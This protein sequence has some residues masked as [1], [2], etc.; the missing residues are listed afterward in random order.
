MKQ[1]TVSPDQTDN[2]AADDTITFTTA[3][4]NEKTEP[5]N[6]LKMWEFNYRSQKECKVALID[7]CKEQA[8]SKLPDCLIHSQQRS[9]ASKSALKPRKIHQ[10]CPD[11]RRTFS[12]ADMHIIRHHANKRA[13]L[14]CFDCHREFT[15]LPDIKVHLQRH[16]STR[17]FVCQFCGRQYFNR[18][19]LGRH[20]NE[21]HSAKNR[22]G[23]NQC[24][25]TF[26][27]RDNLT[28]H[29]KTHSDRRPFPCRFC[30]LAFK[31]SSALRTHER[32]HA[33]VRLHECDLCGKKFRDRSALRL[34]IRSH[35]GERP[36]PCRICDKAF[37]DSST[38]THH[39]RAM[40]SDDKPYKCK[41]CSHQ[42]AISSNLKTHYRRIH[43][44]IVTKVC[45]HIA[46]P[47]EYEGTSLEEPVFR[48][49]I[50]FQ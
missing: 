1:M 27:A 28:K 31:T 49:N 35:T 7:I 37:A 21:N 15:R 46:R 11:C 9:T 34:H 19:T 14:E 32:S 44:V 36:F 4:T 16:S 39:E 10:R 3:S 25:K 47:A 13:P 50:V 5:S 22:F 29:L 48:I 30:S 24:G 42:T 45:K 8:K 33:D 43:K 26:H 18:H 2:Q 17:N 40:H 12:N 38:R 23:C 41:L 20:I 6:E